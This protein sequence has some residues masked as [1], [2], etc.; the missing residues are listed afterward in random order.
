MTKI[1]E[2]FKRAAGYLPGLALAVVIAAVSRFI[3][4]LLP[5]HLIGASVMTVIL[6][7]RCRQPLFL[8]WQ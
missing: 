2:S 5:I 3:E 7:M 1:K 8:I 4:G 6:P